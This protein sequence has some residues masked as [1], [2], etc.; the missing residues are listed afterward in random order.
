MDK[1]I[2]T[3]IERLSCAAAMLL[4]DFAQKKGLGPI[5]VQFLIYL[6]GH[7][8]QFC[9][10]SQL[11]KEFGLTPATV[12]DAVR[13]LKEKRLISGKV[14]RRDRRVSILKPTLSGKACAKEACAWPEGILRRLKKF[15]PHIKQNAMIFFMELIATLQKA[16]IIDVA[17][18]CIVCSNFQRNIRPG[19]KRPH[20]CTLTNR[21][22]AEA[23]LNIDC[24]RHNAKFSYN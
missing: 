9:K 8:E 4:R 24:E 17:R 6:D 15:P 18:M 3:A 21:A 20:Y 11:A 16:G 1:K 13:S 5:Q 12:S 22:I 10:V 19:A 23:E 7:S 2:I 14:S